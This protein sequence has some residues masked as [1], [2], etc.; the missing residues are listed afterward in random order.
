M[1][2]IIFSLFLFTILFPLFV[3]AQ[4]AATDPA[5]S[6][7]GAAPASTP[8][9]SSST[10]VVSNSSS[11]NPTPTDTTPNSVT[12][13]L[14]QQPV[15][16]VKPVST[17]VKTKP[18]AISPVVPKPM[19]VSIDTGS[20]SPP[21]STNNKTEQNVI[22]AL[23]LI[24]GAAVLTFLGFNIQKKNN[25]NDKKCPN[26]KKLMEDKLEELTDFKSQLADL[27]KEK[28]IEQ[29]KDMTQETKIN[30]LIS[31]VENRE[32]EYEKL[33][34][35]YEKCITDLKKT[36]KVIIIHGTEGS[37]EENWFPWLKGKLEDEGVKTF[38]PQFP[39]P[40]A[41]AS[42][43]SEWFDVLEDYKKHIDKNTII[44]G[45][46]LGGVFTLRILEQLKHPIH[47]AYFVG[48]PIGIKPILNY[49]RDQ[50]FSGFDFNWEKIK[51]NAKYFEVFHSDNDP[52]VG[53]ENGRELAKNLGV[54]LS[55]VPK[56]GHFNEK[57]GYTKF[58]GLW[59]KL[60]P[61]L[62]K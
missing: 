5:S 59:E 12:P 52:Y 16:T 42:K 62:T 61:I 37:P 6:S 19:P 43:V 55:F 54:K 15:S 17:V 3:F 29:V 18:K 38:V 13:V 48:T 58:E 50:S 1:K 28:T 27:A 34:E 30:K 10:P 32:E 7:A 46:S 23:F 41:V 35:L 26:I 56:A 60:E 21:I 2:K 22:I 9:D 14:V 40:P 44:V 20:T 25:Q 24:V 49:D 11:T 57:A 45:H 47:S 53:I 51:K 36:K 33:Q 39:S 31:F 8:T 4:G